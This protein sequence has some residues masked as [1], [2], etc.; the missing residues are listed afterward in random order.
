MCCTALEGISR[1]HSQ[2]S[3][4]FKCVLGTQKE[5]LTLYI[6]VTVDEDGK[7]RHVGYSVIN[8]TLPEVH[9]SLWDIYKTNLQ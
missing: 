5:Y 2:N 6:E 4:F 7:N 8:E 9:S 1:T 3:F